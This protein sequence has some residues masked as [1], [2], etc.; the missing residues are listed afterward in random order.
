MRVKRDGL[1]EGDNWLKRGLRGRT[2]SW[3]GLAG[4]GEEGE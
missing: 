1:V 4:R 2:L 3:T